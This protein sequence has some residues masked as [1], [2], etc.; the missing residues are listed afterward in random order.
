MK[1]TILLF[2][3]FFIGTN[4]YAQIVNVEKKRKGNSDGFQGMINAEFNLKENGSTILEFKNAVDLQYKKKSH[5]FIFLNN[6][7]L[8]NVD[9]GAL[10]NDGFQHL[11]FNY[12]VKDSSALTLEA[13]GQYQYNEQKLLKRRMLLGGGPRFR[14]VDNEKLKFYIAPLAMYENELLSDEF[15]TN[16]ETYRLDAYTNIYLELSET[17]DFRMIA[18][19]QPAFSDLSDFRLSGETGIRINFTKHFAYNISYSVDFDNDPPPDVQSI[20]YAWRNKLVF[21]F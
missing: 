3:A 4:L 5:T 17:V 18:Y 6:F 15:E 16:I 19:Y 7:R 8:L 12:T 21:K 9:K 14:L 11:R 2:L 10:I 20:F 1:H 13:F